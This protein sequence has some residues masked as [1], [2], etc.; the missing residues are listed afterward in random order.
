[1]PLD[2]EQPKETGFRREQLLS[3]IRNVLK[4]T[5]ESTFTPD[6]LVGL[7]KQRYDIRHRLETT[8]GSPRRIEQLNEFYHLQEI[9]LDEAK[10][11]LSNEIP[12]ESVLAYITPEDRISISDAMTL[13]YLLV[14]G[15]LDELYAAAQ[16]ELDNS[17]PLSPEE[18]DNQKVELALSFIQ[19][20]RDKNREKESFGSHSFPITQGIEIEYED[21]LLN[22]TK[23][24]IQL[25]KYFI[26]KNI[27]SETAPDS[28][29]TKDR[30]KFKKFK[31]IT[32]VLFG[33]MPLTAELESSTWTA[34][35][36]QTEIHDAYDKLP[37]APLKPRAAV[38]LEV[39]TTP[40]AAYAT[41]LR[42][43]LHAHLAGLINTDQTDRHGHESNKFW[44][45]H[46]TLGGVDLS[47][48]HTEVM[49][50]L[51]IA[52]AAGYAGNNVNE[53]KLE[54]ST[55]SEKHRKESVL[56]IFPFHKR[57]TKDDSQLMPYGE[58][59]LSK[60]PSVEQRSLLKYTLNEFPLLVRFMRFSNMAAYAI[61]AVQRKDHPTQEDLDLANAWDEL[62]SSWK[63]LLQSHTIH[64]LKQ[65]EYYIQDDHYGA[66]QKPASY[67]ITLTR[68]LR[69]RKINKEFTSKA[70]RLIRQFNKQISDIQASY[71]LNKQQN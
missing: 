28:V 65:N 9:F 40:S 33:K 50:I 29:D 17:V 23:K 26:S 62:E 42:E 32:Y 14:G 36:S 71:L 38:W 61:H 19:N 15:K 64:I 51:L 58:K 47:P 43:I 35:K 59:Q 46:Q 10:K 18:M 5:R 52:A 69:E 56:F 53:E 13:Y 54:K 57:R 49:D 31:T 16:K 55:I 7:Q 48:E 25:R 21:P 67:D 70:K 2:L 66:M 22:L 39:A 11:F 27:T 4:R 37:N 6:S 63:I 8:F 45:I 41:Q 60:F 12:R 30:K 1:M 20:V 24:Y 3:L 68:I 44:N 34:L